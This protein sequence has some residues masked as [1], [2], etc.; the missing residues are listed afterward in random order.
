MLYLISVFRTVHHRFQLRPKE[1]QSTHSTTTSLKYISLLSLHQWLSFP[2]KSLLF[3][4]AFQSSKGTW[5]PE[6][7]T[8]QEIVNC[9]FRFLF[10][11]G[12]KWPKQHELP[13]P[14]NKPQRLTSCSVLI[15]GNVI[16]SGISPLVLIAPSTLILTSSVPSASHVTHVSLQEPVS[17]STQSCNTA[18]QIMV[19]LSS[20][21]TGHICYKHLALYITD[22]SCLLGCLYQ[23]FKNIKKNLHR[24]LFHLT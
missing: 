20:H 19:A 6:D 18:T 21:E 12:N 16:A 4:I 5:H 10:C 9:N 7:N 17:P 3:R 23:Q 22:N 24:E 1:M 2:K 8:K 13:P 14:H 15:S 11:G